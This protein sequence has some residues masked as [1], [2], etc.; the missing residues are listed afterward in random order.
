[1]GCVEK[2]VVKLLI[3]KLNKETAS[4]RE[5]LGNGFAFHLLKF[6]F[7]HSLVV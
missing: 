7:T 5:F 1:M 4:K 3:F 2:S 6:S